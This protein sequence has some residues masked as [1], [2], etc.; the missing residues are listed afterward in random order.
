[1]RINPET[2]QSIIQKRN[3]TGKNV[4]S[5]F[6]LELKRDI[7][8]VDTVRKLVASFYRHL[9]GKVNLISKNGWTLYT[10]PE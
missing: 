1:M 6:F 7:T 5:L 2:S 4:F 9:E 10:M 3:F 8:S